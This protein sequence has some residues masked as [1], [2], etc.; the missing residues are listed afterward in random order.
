MPY[1]PLCTKGFQDLCIFFYEHD[2]AIDFHI[3][4]KD[5][6]QKK[7][8]ILMIISTIISFFEK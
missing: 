1:N 4:R 7:K 3:G 2:M 6:K 5:E 8:L